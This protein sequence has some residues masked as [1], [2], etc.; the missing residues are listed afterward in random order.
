MTSNVPILQHPTCPIN[1]LFSCCLHNTDTQVPAPHALVAKILQKEGKKGACEIILVVPV[2]YT[3][4]LIPALMLLNQSDRNSSQ[5][6]VVQAN[7][8]SLV[9][10]TLEKCPQK[11]THKESS[12]N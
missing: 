9:A 2:V 1:S 3:C 12:L 7:A 5:S 4:W 6:A 8:Y 11:C 10:N